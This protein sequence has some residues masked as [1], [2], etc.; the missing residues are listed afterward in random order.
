ML[1]VGWSELLVIAVVLIVVVGP[2]DLPPMLRAFGKM[3]TRLR[4]MAGEF[5]AQF[6][7][8]LREADLDDVRKTIHDAQR[9]DPVNSPRDAMRPLRQTANEIRADFQSAATTPPQPAPSVTATTVHP[10]P[11]VAAPEPVITPQ[12]AE[13]PQQ[14]PAFPWSA[15]GRKAD[16]AKK[17]EA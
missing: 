11:P 8:A 2:K 10:L 9:L 4:S 1:D 17:D 12:M 7:D 14:A 13:R 6:D 16:S 3:T 15:A 5:R